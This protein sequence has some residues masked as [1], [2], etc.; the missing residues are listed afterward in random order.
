MNKDTE[1][2]APAG[3]ASGWGPRIHRANR[4]HVKKSPRKILVVDDN[5]VILQTTSAKLKAAGY[6][7]LTAEDG[8][9]A[10]RQARQLLPHLILLN[11][12]SPPTSVRVAEFPGMVFSILS[13]LRRTNGMEKV[14]VIVITGGDLEKHKDRWV[15][16]GVRDIFLKP[17]DHDALLAAIRWALDQ[18][19]AAAAA[20]PAAP[21]AAAAAARVSSR[22]R[23]RSRPTKGTFRR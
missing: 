8:A 16:A 14:P 2:G 1:N 6:E 23:C 21:A 3:P 10:I 11:P 19:V 7:V 9:S 22:H 4:P 17:I 13:W 15:E 5:R 12:T 18:E 20:A